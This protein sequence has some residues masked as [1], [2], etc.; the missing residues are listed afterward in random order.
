MSNIFL[1][2]PFDTCCRYVNAALIVPGANNGCGQQINIY[3]WDNKVG[4]CIHVIAKR[5]STEDSNKMSFFPLVDT[6]CGPC[7]EC[8]PLG[9]QIKTF[10]IPTS[11][12]CALVLLEGKCAT[13]EVPPSALLVFTTP[14]RWMFFYCGERQSVAGRIKGRGSAPQSSCP[15]GGTRHEGW[16]AQGA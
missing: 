12:L 5:C 7:S 10:H 13:L 8:I 1:H 4:F 15:P 16:E 14:R 9:L 6:P 3:K 2:V 11:N